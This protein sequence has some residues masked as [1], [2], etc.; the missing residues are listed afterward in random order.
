MHLHQC[1]G[2]WLPG[3]VAFC[4]K[5]CCNAK[6]WGEEGGIGLKMPRSPSLFAH[7]G[8]HTIRDEGCSIMAVFIAV[9]LLQPLWRTH[10]PRDP[11]QPG[12]GVDDG[13]V[14]RAAGRCPLA[15]RSEFGG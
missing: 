9:H 3:Y 12:P 10:A 7:L 6:T 2:S 8:I 15:E 5:F 14:Q 1:D 13:V 11:F 4:P